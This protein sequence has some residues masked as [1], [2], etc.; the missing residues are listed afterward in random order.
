MLFRSLESAEAALAADQ[1]IL[2]DLIKSLS[3]QLPEA[4]VSALTPEQA[5]Q[6][7]EMLNAKTTRE[8]LG[9]FQRLEQMLAQ[10]AGRQEQRDQQA[11][12]QQAPFHFS[13]ASGGATAGAPGSGGFA[14]FVISSNNRCASRKRGASSSACNS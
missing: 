3:E 9:M 12:A 8:A 14:A 10:H 4:S 2:D 11:G 7:Q 5:A 6:L 1:E 13:F